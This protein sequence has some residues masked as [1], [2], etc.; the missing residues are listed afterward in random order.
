MVQQYLSEL[1]GFEDR[2]KTDT[3]TTHENNREIPLLSMFTHKPP[4]A[5][6]KLKKII[7]FCSVAYHAGGASDAVQIDELHCR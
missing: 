2:H 4:G 7:E 3:E 6:L 5:R 1:R